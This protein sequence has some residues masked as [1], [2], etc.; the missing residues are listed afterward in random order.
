MNI[1]SNNCLGGFVYKEV[2]QTQYSNPLIWHAF[3]NP[4]EYSSFIKDFDKL[5]FENIMLSKDSDGLKNNFIIDIDEKYKIFQHH[6]F[7]D[8]NATVP[9]VFGPNGND[10]KYNHI[11]EYIVNNFIRRTERMKKE[12]NILVLFY[13]PYDKIEKHQ[14]IVD[15]IAD[16]KYKGLIFSNQKL[17]LNNDILQFPVN[18]NWAKEK[19]GWHNSFM[20]TYKDKLKEIILKLD[21]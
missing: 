3:V 20:K 16:K 8:A 7:F 6:M 14:Q 12:K 4:Q 17:N 21:K 11:W 10:I 1:I 9:T 2:L 5:N 18:A 15:A 19:Y 13:D